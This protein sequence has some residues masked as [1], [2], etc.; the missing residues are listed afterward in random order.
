M[1]GTSVI[2]ISLIGYYSEKRGEILRAMFIVMLI[3]AGVAPYTP[4]AAYFA[5]SLQGLIGEVIFRSKKLFQLSAVIF[6]ALTLALSS[7]QKFLMLTIVYGDN[8]W[9]SIN[10][11]GLYVSSKFQIIRPVDNLSLWIMGIYSGIHILTGIILGIVASGLPSKISAALEDMGTV[12]VH[13]VNMSIS[14]KVKIKKKRKFWLKKP[15]AILI[16][17]LAMNIVILSYFFPEFSKSTGTKAVI[18]ILRSIVIMTLWFFLISPYVRKLYKKMFRKKRSIYGREVDSIIN[19]LP[20]LKAVVN[21]NWRKQKG[22]RFFKR[23][24]QFTVL[25]LTTIIYMETGEEEND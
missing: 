10:S 16:L 25:T 18:M 14:D 17:L 21:D 24:T 13:P 7:I 15:T 22:E 4:P 2:F 12:S 8:L 3:K 20:V 19:S 9:E 11:F 6:G 5:V 23:I 1:N